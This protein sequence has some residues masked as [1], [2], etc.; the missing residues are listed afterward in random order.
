MDIHLYKIIHMM[1]CRN[2]STFNLWNTLTYGSSF[3]GMPIDSFKVNDFCVNL[4][5]VSMYISSAEI[6]CRI[7]L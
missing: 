7:L 2:E 3:Q 5:I 1:F 6:I 4:F